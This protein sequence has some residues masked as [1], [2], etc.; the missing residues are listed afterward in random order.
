MRVLLAAISIALA[1]GC[2]ASHDDATKANPDMHPQGPELSFSWAEATQC[3]VPRFEALG[4]VVDGEVWVMGGFLSSGLNVTE[5][6]DIYDPGTDT[7]RVGPDLAG[8]QTHAGVVVVGSELILAGGF[9]GN[10]R[11]R[12]TSATVWRW[13]VQHAAW[14]RG[15]DF[16][17]RRAAVAMALVGSEIHAAGGL[18]EDGNTDSEEHVVL[19]LAGTN[20]WSNAPPLPVARNHG[21]AAAA[22]GLFFAVA[23]RHAWDEVAGDEARLDA[24]DP[25]TNAWQERTSMRAPRSEIGAST[26]VTADGRLLVIGGSIPGPLPSASVLVYD[27]REDVWSSLP[28]LPQALK[29]AVAA[30]VGVKVVVTTGSPT[31]TDP[32][33]T[34]YVGC[35]L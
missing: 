5:R 4:A 6:V 22:G 2:A 30:R 27:P 10:V 33:A 25:S 18:T 1:N 7:W 19:D 29:G 24:F 34:T 26:L 16:P 35:C 13:S 3:P 9:V 12:A 14:T 28:D 32:S 8:A 31:S 17:T 21:G 15:P 20:G 23:G 11:S